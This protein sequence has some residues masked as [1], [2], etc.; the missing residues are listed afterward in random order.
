[1]AV[2][3][4]I[5]SCARSREESRDCAAK[6]SASGWQPPA[7]QPC[8]PCLLPLNRSSPPGVRRLASACPTATPPCSP[9]RSFAAVKALP[10]TTHIV[11]A[12]IEQRQHLFGMSNLLPTSTHHRTLLTLS[13]SERTEP[14]PH[15][16]CS[17]HPRLQLQIRIRAV[18]GANF[19]PI[20]ICSCR[21][22]CYLRMCAH[23]LIHDGFSA[24]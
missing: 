17:L 4:L 20:K 7:P 18:A 11:S 12:A 22:S 23:L 14:L 24:S 9:C 8:Q 10:S 15:E 13:A 21:K 2:C 1:M 16:S 3:F 5:D 6:F 19:H